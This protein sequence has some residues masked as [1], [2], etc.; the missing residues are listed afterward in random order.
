MEAYGKILLIAM[1]AFF[2]LVLLEKAWGIWKGQDTVPVSDMIASLSSGITNVTKD[3][4]GLSVAVISY[5]W[6]FTQFSFFTIEATWAVYVIAFFA[7]DFAGY[8]THR[9]NHE[10]NIFWNNHIVHHSSEEF[11][12]ACALR[13]SISSIFKIFAIFLLPAAF[14]GVPPEVIGVVA[15]LHLFAQF[16]YHT[17]HIRSL[18]FLEKIIVTPAHH[19]VHH[20]INPEYLD[21]NYGQIFIFWDKW[22]GTFQ[23]ERADI[24]AVYGVTR[25][26]QTWNP[27]KINF[28]HLWLLIQ[29]AWRAKNWGDKLKIW[30]M[31]LGWRPSD[32]AAKHPVAKIQDVYRFDKYN[33]ELNGSMRI[34][35][36]G[37][38]IV[39]LLLLSYLFSNL[40]AIG[41]PGIFYYGGFVFLTVFAY[42][43]LM[44]RNPLAWCW[45][46]LKSSYALY[47]VFTT[48]DWF[49]LNA[50]FP[51][52][53]YVFV[54]Y[55]VISTLSSLLFSLQKPN[56]SSSPSSHFVE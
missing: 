46:T 35:S 19:R 29:D 34:W 38:L 2:V 42:T 50:Q 31:P 16:W 30:F 32:V 22:F 23:E 43:E 24:P 41:A 10:Y 28:M 20:A 13:Q 11:N 48:G 33:P 7:L 26:V 39:L 14:L 51:G 3:V 53:V 55:L 4:L 37:Q 9:I 40:A 36:F 49:G 18:G 56:A 6:L 5:Q 8:W 54:G 17:Q 1:P 15:P 27:I 52:A 21:K 44:D 45:E 47:F 12:L 25:P